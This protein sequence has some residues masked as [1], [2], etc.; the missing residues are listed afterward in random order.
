MIINYLKK[1]ITKKLSIVTKIYQISYTLKSGFRKALNRVGFFNYFIFMKKIVLTAAVFALTLS[2]AFSQEFKPKEKEIAV[3][4]AF[5]SPFSEA[6]PFSLVNGISGRYFFKSDLAFRVALNLNRNSETKFTYNGA[7][8]EATS[9]L[10]SNLDLGLNLGAEKHFAGTDRL[11]PYAGADLILGFVNKSRDFKDIAVTANSETSKSLD[12]KI[13][14]RLL[15]GADFYIYPKV[16]VGT[17]FGISI[18]SNMPGDQTVTK[19]NVS[20]VKKPE[21]T[22]S[23]I[24][25]NMTTGSF[26]IGFR[27]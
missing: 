3:G 15:A 19:G 21:I 5:D 1:I 10:N 22:N 14:V 17:E 7:G 26:R 24:I 12:T 25:T 8:A 20:E 27:F 13:G 23:D 2:T 18:I 16:Y 6:K 4:I 9:D 11:D